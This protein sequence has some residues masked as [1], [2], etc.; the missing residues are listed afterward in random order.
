LTTDERKATDEKE[1]KIVGASLPPALLL[2]DIVAD[3]CLPALDES[4]IQI[5]K[6]YVR[7]DNYEGLKQVANGRL[8]PMAGPRTLLSVAEED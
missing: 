3:C 1:E 5:L 4:D 6:T 2:P 7:H 8:T